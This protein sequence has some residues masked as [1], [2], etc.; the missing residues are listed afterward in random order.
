M[1][2]GLH[3]GPQ[4]EFIAPE[5]MLDF[6]RRAEDFGF[7]PI[8]F[9][10]TVSLA[11][12]HIRDP[13]VAL[14]LAAGATRTATI[15]TCVTNPLTRHLSVTANAIASIDDLCPGRT[16][17]GI[18]TG[19]TAVH[20]VG[21]D[22]ARLGPMREALSVLRGL[23]DGTPVEYDG[24]RLTSNWRKTDLPIYLAA[25]GPRT[26]ELGG[27]VADGVITLAGLDADVLAWVRAR[28]REGEAKAG[29][30]S[31]TVPVWVDGLVSLGDDREATRDAIRP[32]IASLANQNF[33]SA[34]H[35]VP[36]ARVSEVRAFREAYDETDL[37]PDSK[38]GRLVTDY[39]L[40]RFGIVGTQADAIGR[41][42]AL[43]EQ[44]VETFLIA[45]PFTQAQRE[46]VLET[47]G[48]EVIPRVGG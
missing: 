38:N 1:R 24:A 27:E 42:E 41:F 7:D 46:A 18:G 45:Q 2:I 8:T 5:R 43:A 11:R 30:G 37:G 22:R 12:F 13:Y 17:L 3:I 44:G 26:L 25:G 48:R 15:G 21:L 10:D 20:L 32:R 33:R 4:N 40:D 36:E 19:D 35:G 9:A 31:G 23:L 39:I 16:V 6:V 28:V 34:F 47:V 29:R 14:A